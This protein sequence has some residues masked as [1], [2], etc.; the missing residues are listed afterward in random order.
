MGIY[1]Q[2]LSSV[3]SHGKLLSSLVVMVPRSELNRMRNDRFWHA[4]NDMLGSD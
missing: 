1:T 2:C 4:M 3:L